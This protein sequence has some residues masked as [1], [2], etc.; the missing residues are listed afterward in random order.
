ME[1]MKILVNEL[2]KGQNPNLKDNNVKSIQLTNSPQIMDYNIKSSQIIKSRKNS[3]IS[4]G[5]SEP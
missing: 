4:R 5:N 1:E 2:K 3:L